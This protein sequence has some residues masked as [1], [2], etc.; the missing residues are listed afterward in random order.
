MSKQGQRIL[1][2]KIYIKGKIEIITGL[3][4][5]GS[6]DS[7][8]IGGT[9]LTVIKDSGNN[10]PY[11]PGSSLKGK[12]RSALEKFGERIK[13][14]K[15][16][17]L[18]SNRNIG[19][20][21]NKLF[22]HCCD[23][24][25]YAGNC[26]VCR[27]FGSSGDDRSMPRGQK[28]ENFPSFLM[29]RDCL[30][31]DPLFDSAKTYTE[32]KTETGVDRVNMAANPRKVERVLP[33]TVFNFEMIYSV[34][35]ITLSDQ[36]EPQFPEENLKKDIDNILTCM[37]IIQDEGLGGYSS[38]GYGKVKF[39]ITELSGKSLEYFKG[40]TDKTEKMPKEQNS[41][42]DAR[43]Y[44]VNIVKFLKQESYN[45]LSNQA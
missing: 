27:I 40:K 2:G 22:I 25:K 1:F 21:R 10:F 14:G 23:D 18:K 17:K 39:E 24:I 43:K 11:I 3:H 20:F 33:G 9:D 37:E 13:D 12:L 42:K 26:D 41:I 44:I 4:I 8:Q 15:P 5:G 32:I 34:D 45:E 28:A 7:F 31:D 6:Q 16:E 30:I 35:G 36:K 38:R 29:V 19:T